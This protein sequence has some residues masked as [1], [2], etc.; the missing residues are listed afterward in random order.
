VAALSIGFLA[1]HWC[2]AAPSNP[3]PAKEPASYDFGAVQQLDSFVTYLQ[4][5]GQT[6]ILHRFDDYSNASL[7]SQEYSDLGMTLHLLK[8]LRN[9]QTNQVVRL[10]EGR[11]DAD[12]IAVA[13]AY[14]Q[15]PPATRDQTSL[16]VFAR[17]KDYRAQYPSVLQM[18]DAMASAFK[19]LDGKTP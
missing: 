7:A 8:E 19:I 17:A 5:T 12:V 1:A 2:A 6:N 13:A 16:K 10:L 9:G 3:P 14:R 11:L 15:L 4:D 18:D